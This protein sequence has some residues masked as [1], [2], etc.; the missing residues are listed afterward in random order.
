MYGFCK[1]KL[2]GGGGWALPY[3]AFTGVHSLAGYD[4]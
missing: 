1:D 3:L 2:T 4:F